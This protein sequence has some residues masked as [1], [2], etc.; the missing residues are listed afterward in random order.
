MRNQRECFALHIILTQETM[1]TSMA[2]IASAHNVA[3]NCDQYIRP[4][5]EMYEYARRAIIAI[6]QA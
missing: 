2:M 1:S 6:T 4:K 5:Y 3:E